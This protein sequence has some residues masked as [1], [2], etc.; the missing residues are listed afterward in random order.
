MLEAALKLETGSAEAEQGCTEARIWTDGTGL[1]PA[2]LLPGCVSFGQ[3]DNLSESV[4]SLVKSNPH[5][6]HTG[7]AQE[8]HSTVQGA[9]EVP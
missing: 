4:S 8:G 9:G 2:L 1:N 7:D 6:R 5:Y 3:G